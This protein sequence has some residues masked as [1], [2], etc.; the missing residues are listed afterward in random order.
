MLR[1]KGAKRLELQKMDEK[2]MATVNAGLF[3]WKIYMPLWYLQDHYGGYAVEQYLRE[4]AEAQARLLKDAGI[5][6]PMNLFIFNARNF[7]S[8]YDSD[9]ELRG[10]DIEATMAVRGCNEL[11]YAL[12]WSKA[13]PQ[14]G[15][16]RESHCDLCVKSRF[17]HIAA[18]FG[19]RYN[20]RFTEKGCVMSMRRTK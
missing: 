4:D 15:I 13:V 14:K 6:D 19:F 3:L 10:D 16:T 2:E 12:Q 20:I 5:G 8:A 1:K 7:I 11:A 17:R 18:K 9:V